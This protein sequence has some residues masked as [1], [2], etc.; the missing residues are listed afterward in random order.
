MFTAK[1]WVIASVGMWFLT[2][3]ATMG[4]IDIPALIGYCSAAGLALLAL[5]SKYRETKRA[6]D[7]RDREAQK[8]DCEE[9]LK[10]VRD[11]VD[12][13]EKANGDLKELADQWKSMAEQHRG[14]SSRNHGRKPGPRS[15]ET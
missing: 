1:F 14:H 6:Q 13:L 8:A 11:R 15:G 7:V 2:F 3:A 10:A 9:A 5:Y 12:S 4:S